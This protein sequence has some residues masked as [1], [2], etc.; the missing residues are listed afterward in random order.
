MTAIA[1]EG[2][3][4]GLK[5]GRMSLDIENEELKMP[6]GFQAGY[7]FGNGFAVEG[8]YNKSEIE[9]FGDDKVDFTTMALY[10]VYRY[11]DSFY[12]KLKAGALKEEVKVSADSNSGTFDD[13]GFSG[14]LGI[15]YRFDYFSLEA[16]YV[17]IESDVSYLSF[18]VNFHF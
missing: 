5:T 6:I 12:G 3:Y 18:G 1:S 7:D 15:G 14:G 11:G 16:E 13:T 8:E 2:V 17:I 4:L 10:G 9:S